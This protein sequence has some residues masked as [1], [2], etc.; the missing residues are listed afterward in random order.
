M[1]FDPT[2]ANALQGQ[3]PVVKLRWHLVGGNNR[4]DASGNPTE[5]WCAND[6]TYVTP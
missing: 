3:T 4:Y 5:T 2:T 6:L 1:E